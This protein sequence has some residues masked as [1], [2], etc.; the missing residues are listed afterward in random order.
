MNDY[1]ITLLVTYSD[2]GLV[3]YVGSQ[4]KNWIYFND[5]YFYRCSLGGTNGEYLFAGHWAKLDTMLSIQIG[6]F[7][8]SE[9][10]QQIAALQSDMMSAKYAIDSLDRR[11]A[12]LETK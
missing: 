2:R 9:I 5:E 10:T 1:I 6:R 12:R 4:Y 3:T 11:V 7:S 8:P